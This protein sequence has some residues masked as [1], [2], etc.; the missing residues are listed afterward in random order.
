[1]TLPGGLACP[2]DGALNVLLELQALALALSLDL[3]RLGLE[4]LQCAA[5]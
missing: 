3:A 1:L 2:L 4:R 5:L